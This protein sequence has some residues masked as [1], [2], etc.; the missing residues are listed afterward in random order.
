[1]GLSV[2][3]EDVL[4]QKVIRPRLFQKDAE[5][6]HIFTI[7]SLRRMQNLKLLPL[8][9]RTYRSP[10]YDSLRCKVAGMELRNPFIIPAGFDKQAEALW[11]LE[12][13]GVGAVEIGTVTLRPQHGNERPR[14]FRNEGMQAIFN[15]Y[16]F[17]SDGAERVAKRLWDLHD[18]S[19]FRFP[20]PIGV[21]I[22]KN[23]ET[24]DKDA[25]K[26]YIGAFRCFA[27]VLR[28][29]DWVKINISSPNTPE[30]RGIFN[31]LDEFLAE[32][33]ETA[34]TITC[35]YWGACIPS[36]DYR[37]MLK[38][39]PDGLTERDICRIVELCAKYGI[40]AIE[41]TNTTTNEKIKDMCG[42]SGQAGG[43]SGAPLKYLADQSLRMMRDAAKDLNIDL[44]GVG[45]IM[46]GKDAI[47]KRELGA[48]AV[49]V[50]TGLVFQGPK[51]IHDILL[52]W[53]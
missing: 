12:A 10:L 49:Q 25:V 44:I 2:E 11:A 29:Q 48:Q 26:D 16:G 7:Q 18:G 53:K 39:P 22:G 28:P 1:M 6:A 32:F 31:R 52:A 13:L 23:K 21:S 14:V 37:F 50:Y 4:W 3:R 36:F 51:L 46:S 15:R 34:R 42:W 24:P 5:D 17:N 38:I 20:I 43:V 8:I 19:V 40:P 33:T 9:R 47:T 41:A 45:G 27:G 30:L 35:R